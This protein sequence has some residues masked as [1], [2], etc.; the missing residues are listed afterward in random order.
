MKITIE[1]VSRAAYPDPEPPMYGVWIPYK[2]WLNPDKNNPLATYAD[3]DRRRAKQVARRVGQGARVYFVDKSLIQLEDELK[4]REFAR[5][6]A[7]LSARIRSIIISMV[8]RIRK[9]GS[10]KRRK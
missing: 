10:R 7:F 6:R 4:R 5:Q 2:G 8:D 9:V 3:R 1:H